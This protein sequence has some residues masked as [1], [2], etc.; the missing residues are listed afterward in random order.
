MLWGQSNHQLKNVNS[1]IQ[2]TLLFKIVDYFHIVSLLVIQLNRFLND[3]LS[4]LFGLIHL[5]RF[6]QSF[7]L[8]VLTLQ[9]RPRT[10]L[11]FLRNRVSSK[12]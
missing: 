4:N 7:H 5:V 1:Y 9:P 8:I 10:F 2:E 3:T 12:H 11:H 6:H